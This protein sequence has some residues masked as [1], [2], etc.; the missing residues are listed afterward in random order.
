M[1]LF[2]RQRVLL[3]VSGWPRTLGNPASVR[4]VLGLLVGTLLSGLPT[5]SLLPQPLLR[6]AETTDSITGYITGYRSHQ[7]LSSACIHV[8]SA[9]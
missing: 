5:L 4:Q 6:E 1:G 7:L 9:L 2:L 3:C 8:L